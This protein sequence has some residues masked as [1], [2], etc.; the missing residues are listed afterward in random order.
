MSWNKKKFRND[1]PKTPSLNKY[2]IHPSQKKGKHFQ[3][4]K[5]KNGIIYDRKYS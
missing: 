5:K 2:V 1:F 3:P 4:F